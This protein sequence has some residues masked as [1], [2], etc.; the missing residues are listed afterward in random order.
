MILQVE[1]KAA[2]IIADLIQKMTGIL[3]DEKKEVILYLIEKAMKNKDKSNEYTVKVSKEDYET[4]MSGRELL[5]EAI[6]RDTVL[7]VSE[8]SSLK[9]NQ[10]FIETDLRIINCSLDV[11]LNNLVTDLKLIGGI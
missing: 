9:K 7:N 3:V 2:G 8:D 10:C 4:V 11:Q 5:L 6:G 1:P